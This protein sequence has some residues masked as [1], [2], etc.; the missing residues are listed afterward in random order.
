MTGKQISVE[1]LMDLINKGLPS[2]SAIIDVR[3]PEEFSKGAI[4]GAINI[5]VD[6]V[7]NNTDKLKGFKKLYIHCLS[8]GRSQI[9]VA[10]LEA[11][12]LPIELYNVTSG[13]LA[14]RKAGYPLQ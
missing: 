12:N 9:A 14:W 13:I 8:G 3:T 1:E 10:Q 4:S 11:L 6:Q 2:D 7:A 5:P